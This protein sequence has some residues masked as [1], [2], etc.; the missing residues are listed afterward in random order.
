M[1]NEIGHPTNFIK[2]MRYAKKNSRS[3]YLRFEWQVTVKNETKVK[4]VSLPRIYLISKCFD[5]I[6]IL[7]VYRNLLGYMDELR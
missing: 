6:I 7:Q 5:S 3:H 1:F 4:S 2:N